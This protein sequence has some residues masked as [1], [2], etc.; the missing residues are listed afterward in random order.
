[1]S[2]ELRMQCLEL[3][4]RTA[5]SD[6]IDKAREFLGFVLAE[7]AGQEPVPT[8]PIAERILEKVAARH[9]VP[10][11]A[12]IGPGRHSR[13]VTVRDEAISEVDGATQMSLTAL[14]RLFCRDHTSILASLRRS[15]ARGPGHKLRRVA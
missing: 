10:V 6:P 13:L 2:S 11:A 5:A 14:G 7:E 4:I 1:M 3:A 12:I 8:N 9:N 15:G